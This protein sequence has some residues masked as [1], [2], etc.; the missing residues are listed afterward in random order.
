ME[1]KDLLIEG[2][3]NDQEELGS[4]PEQDQLNESVEPDMRF[5]EP[6]EEEQPQQA[7]I[8]SPFNK[9][10][11][12]AN[13]KEEKRKK[14]SAKRNKMKKNFSELFS[15]SNIII[16]GILRFLDFGLNIFSIGSLIAAIWIG[17]K[18]MM[19]GNYLMVLSAA[20]LIGVLIYLN[21]EIN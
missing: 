20:V 17:I 13:Y 19:V 21:K 7:P 6:E 16:I 18:F 11:K 9:E 5:E 10:F 1:N 8:K 12:K 14:K 4:K 15:T 2:S 3:K